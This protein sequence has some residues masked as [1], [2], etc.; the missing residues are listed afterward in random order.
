MNRRRFLT[1]SA[2]LALAPA[3]AQSQTPPNDRIGVAVIGCGGMGRNDLTDFQ[4][5]PEVEIRAVCDAFRPSAD[6]ARQLTSG[7]AEVFSDFR[8]VLERKDIDA[9]V[10]ATPDHWHALMAVM[11]CE[12]GKDVYVEKPACVA[13]RAAKTR[14]KSSRRPRIVLSTKKD[15]R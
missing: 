4:K 13:I 8:Q 12:A 15:C 9:V 3:A 14:V 1:D 10:I 6:Q 7:R 2:G 5:Q 11:A